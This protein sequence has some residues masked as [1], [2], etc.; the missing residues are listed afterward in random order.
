MIGNSLFSLLANVDIRRGEELRTDAEAL[1]K[2]CVSPQARY[3]FVSDYTV[4][5]DE[6]SPV[7]SP[8]FF[9]YSEVEQ[10]GIFRE[11]LGNANYLGSVDDLHYFSC[12]TTTI[13]RNLRE[14]ALLAGIEAKKLGD[15][16]C[17]PKTRDR[18]LHPDTE[19]WGGLAWGSIRNLAPEWTPAEAGLA[20]EAVALNN[21]WRSARFCAECGAKIE[22]QNS[23]WNGACQR[24]HLLFPRTDL[25]VIMAITDDDDRLLLAHNGNWEQGRYSVVAGFVEAG[26]TPEAAVRRE[27]FEETQIRVGEVTYAGSQPWPFPKSLM[28]GY[29]GRVAQGASTRVIPD[30]VE[31]TEAA[32]FSREE[33]MVALEERRVMVPGRSSIAYMLISD[34]AGEDLTRFISW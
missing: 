15:G 27:V 6:K 22:V 18:V 29:R 26:E 10:N 16:G 7:F 5:V 1:G 8:R 32:F 30:G 20:V 17:R 25:A 31:I 28:L 14:K 12:D 21:M 13:V 24:G 4:A 33:F 34:W 3:L 2:I 11:T 23:G 19:I 9:T